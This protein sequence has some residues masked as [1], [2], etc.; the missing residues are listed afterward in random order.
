MSYKGEALFAI[1]PFNTCAV[2]ATRGDCPASINGRNVVEFEISESGESLD[3]HL[4]G[5]DEWPEEFGLYVWKGSIRYTGSKSLCSEDVDGDIE[6]ETD[7]IKPATMLD[8]V[9]FNV[10]IKAS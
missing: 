10:D 5:I 8:F 7:S 6:W 3:H 4:Y 2:I 9:H 1:G